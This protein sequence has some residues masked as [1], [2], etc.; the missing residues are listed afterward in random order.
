MKTQMAAATF[1]LTISVYGTTP[2]L[3]GSFNDRGTDWT[4]AER[5]SPPSQSTYRGTGYQ[6]PAGPFASSW[7][8]G[9]M[10]SQY[11]GPFS[12]SAR[13]DSEQSCDLTPTVGFNR[14]SSFPTC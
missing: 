3:A 6:A 10:P 1:V 11:S 13:P 9:R 7:G 4:T 2:A 8:S 14:G 12:P 5:M